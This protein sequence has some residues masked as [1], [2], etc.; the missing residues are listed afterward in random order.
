ME[1]EERPQKFRKLSHET[2]TGERVAAEDGSST[3]TVA[4]K[5][6]S[7]SG[8]AT[9]I[10][11]SLQLGSTDVAD[12]PPKQD[13]D[14]DNHLEAPAVSKPMSKNQLK[15]LRRDQ[16]WEAGREGRKAKRR[17]KTKDKR[18]RK[19][20]ARDLERNPKDAEGEGDESGIMMPSHQSFSSRKRIRHTLLPVTILLDCQFNDLMKSDELISLGAQLTRCYSDINRASFKPHMIV[21]SWGGVLK[22]RFDT[23]LSKQYENWKGVKFTP[24]GFLE[25][26]TE[27]RERMRG[28]REGTMAGA[29]SAYA[30][31]TKSEEEEMASGHTAD[32]PDSQRTCSEPLDLHEEIVYLTADSP[33]TLT[34]LSPYSTYI[35]GALVDKNRHKGIC[36]KIARD[37][38][39]DASDNEPDQRAKAFRTAKLPIGEYMSMQSRSVLTTNHVCEI[40]VRWLECG[41]WGEAFTRVLPQRKGAVLKTKAAVAEEGSD[42]DR[43][44]EQIDEDSNGVAEGDTPTISTDEGAGSERTEVRDE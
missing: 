18:E 6:L 23:I 3:S 41:D 26:A 38:G 39:A 27:A 30:N 34:H 42:Y 8:T 40:M 22:E 24:H 1:A 12:I 11:D 28:P 31:S 43:G 13:Q 20:Q 19:R 21:S 5:T 32:H 17:Q 14:G 10:A 2:V 29:F 15:K 4:A 7:D 44:E 36:Y 33:H 9:N 37:A 25:A 16:K 35:V